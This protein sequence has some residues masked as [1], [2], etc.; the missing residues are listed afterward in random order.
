MRPCGFRDAKLSHC[1]WDTAPP[2]PTDGTSHTWKIDYDPGADDGRGRLTVWLDDRKDSFPAPRV[3]A[4]GGEVLQIAPGLSVQDGACLLRLYFD[5]LEYTSVGGES[6]A[7]VRT[8][9]GHT[10]SVMAVAFSPDGKVLA[11]S[12]RD[13]TSSCGTRRPASWCGR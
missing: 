11:S 9:E 4:S 5:D 10:S 2:I 8:L 7:S 12:S 3:V 6:A 13:K 1:Q